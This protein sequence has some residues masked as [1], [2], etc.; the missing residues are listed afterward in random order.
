MERSGFLLGKTAYFQGLT[1]LFVS[2]RYGD[3]RF[4]L[5][6]LQGMNFLSLLL[7]H[8]ASLKA[9][10]WWKLG[11]QWTQWSRSWKALDGMQP[12]GI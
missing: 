2:G 7:N 4:P 11:S 9:V 12:L 3:S 1:E 5:S 10:Q 6:H 8:T